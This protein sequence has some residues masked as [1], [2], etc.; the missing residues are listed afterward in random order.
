[1]KHLLFVILFAPSFVGVAQESNKKKVVVVP[2]SRFEFVSE[3]EIAEIAAKNNV[4]EK[5]VFFT[6][7]KNMLN[8]FEQH[9]DENFEFVAITHDAIRPY[10]NLIKYEIG[11]FKGKKFNSANLK[12]ITEEQF[13]KLL[14]QFNA[15]FIVF[16]TWYDIQKESFVRAGKYTKRVDYAG[17]YIDYDVFNLFKQRVVGEARVKAIAPEPNDEQASYSLLR[18]TEVAGAYNN[19]ITHIIEQISKPLD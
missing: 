9:Q 14:E 2:Y 16:V 6:Y 10:K 4:T 5:E 3:F 7:Q 19:F 15:D 17:H 8:S 12:A 18:T 13:S 1:V 11:K